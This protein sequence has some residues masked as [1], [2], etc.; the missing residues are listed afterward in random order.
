MEQILETLKSQPIFIL[1]LAF[2]AALIVYSIVKKLLKILAVLALILVVYLGYLVY[3]GETITLSKKHLEQYKT[4][5]INDIKNAGPTD[6]QKI[7]DRAGKIKKA[8]TE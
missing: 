7:M 3:R 5:K 8:V 2:L 6:I 4:Q 1:V